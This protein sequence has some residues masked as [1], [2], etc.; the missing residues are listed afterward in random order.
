MARSVKDFS[1]LFLAGLVFFLLV[2]FLVPFIYSIKEPYFIMPIELGR[3]ISGEE[4]LPI[5][6]DKYGDG[7]FG[8]KRRN[9][10]VHKGLDLEAAM[11]SPVY[12][13][14]TGYARFYSVPSGYGNLVIISHPGKYETRYGH[15][16]KSVIKRPR[17]VKQ[18]ELIGYTGKTGN[19]N[20][21]G[22]LPH[23]HFE[24]RHNRMPMD[25]AK[26]LIKS[27]KGGKV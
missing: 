10:R 16:Y 7:A 23:V 27:I 6:N 20:S 3:R 5:R 21:E 26:D 18:G 12:A 14:K 13:S 15:L 11:K 19:A 9:G 24:I 8:A 17:W 1:L 25:P 2:E 4:N 22:L